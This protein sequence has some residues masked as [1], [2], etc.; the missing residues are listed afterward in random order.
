MN[1]IFSARVWLSKKTSAVLADASISIQA[2]GLGELTIK[3]LR[4]ME[5]KDGLW[6]ALPQQEYKDKAGKRAFADVLWASPEWKK[7]IE[8]AV[9]AEFSAVKAGKQTVNA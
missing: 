7:E 2:V 6:V 9:L 3:K 1:I 8:N 4:V 5:G